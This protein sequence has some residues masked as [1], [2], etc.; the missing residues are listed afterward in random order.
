VEWEM[1][2]IM[3]MV[4]MMWEGIGNREKLSFQHET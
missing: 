3:V 1:M 2:M 4:A